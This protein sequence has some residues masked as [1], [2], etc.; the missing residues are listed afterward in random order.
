MYRH[1]KE[2]HYT[3]GKVTERLVN[4][5]R[6]KKQFR[7]E[8]LFNTFENVAFKDD[9]LQTYKEH[10]TKL[11]A[12]HVHLVGSGPSLFIMFKDKKQAENMYNSCK[13]QGMKAYMAETS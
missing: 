2:S 6:E 10:L 11:S 8:M 12:P 4:V 3:D 9:Q 1:W 7:T 13:S 5:I